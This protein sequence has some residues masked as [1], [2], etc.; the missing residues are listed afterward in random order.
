MDMGHDLVL[1]EPLEVA[2]QHRARHHMGMDD[3]RREIGDH[4]PEM[5]NSPHDLSGLPCLVEAK[6]A[7][8][9]LGQKILVMAA[10]RHDRHLM[11]S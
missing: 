4:L 2:G 7:D 6:M 5:K 9:M 10:S 11:I 8:A 1:A 3:V